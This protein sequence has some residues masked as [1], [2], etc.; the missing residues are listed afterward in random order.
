MQEVHKIN[1]KINFL[2]NGLAY[3]SFN[4]NIKLGFIDSFQFL[5]SSLDNLVKN[6]NKDDIK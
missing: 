4:I 5:S 2:P 3:M 1:F 6:L